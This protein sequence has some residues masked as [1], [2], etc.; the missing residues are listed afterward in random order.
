MYD[1]LFEDDKMHEE[2]GI[3]GVFSQ[4]PD[5]TSQLVYYGLFALQHRGQESAGIAINTGGKIEYHKDMGLVSDVL[6][7]DVIDRLSGGISIG[8]VRYSTSGGSEKENAQPLVVRYKK[9]KLAFAHNGNLVNADSMREILED[10]GVIFQTSID[11]EVVANM[12]ARNSNGNIVKSIKNVME[13]IK[14]AFAFVVMTEKE[15]IG[16]RDHFGLRPLCLGKR[17]D[18]YLLASES[19]AI[20]AMGGEFIRDIEPG[21]IV[22]INENGVESIKSKKYAQRKSCM[23]EYVYFAR[24]DSNIDGINVYQARYNA[25]KMLAKEAPVK[26]DL[27]FSVPDSGTPAAIGYSQE[28]GIPFGLGLIKNRYAKR[29]FIEPN[30][31]LREQGV[32]TKLSVLNEIVKEKIVVIID[33]S[34][35]RGT[36]T[37]QIV[38]MVKDSGAKEVHVRIASPPVTHSCF[39]GIDTPFRQYLIGATKTIEEIKDFIKADSIHY[40]SLDGLVNSTNSNQGFC[41]ACLNGDYPMEVPKFE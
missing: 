10:D 23:F 13:I 25:G 5:I 8:H 7:K 9:G 11:T 12:V 15:L 6:K 20:N 19:C 28:L 33:D 37:R 27:V 31:E 41:L 17:L 21:E 36:T 34:I 35:V 40:L 38:Q 18:G 22:I 39:F 24:P 26:A 14:G 4:N 2:C 29:T 3:V 32:K 1:K 30:Q 16:V